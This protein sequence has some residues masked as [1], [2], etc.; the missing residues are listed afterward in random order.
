MLLVV[1]LFLFTAP[2]SAGTLAWSAEAIPSTVG[3]VLGPS[4]IDVRDIAVAANGTTIYAVPGDSTSDNVVYESNDAG[5]SWT[6]LGVDIKA[7]VVAVAPDD[8]HVVAIASKSAPAVWVTSNGGSTW[9]SLGTPQESGGAAAAIIHDIAISPASEGTHYIAVAG[10]EEND[11]ANVWYFD[12]GSPS[13]TWS[14]TNTLPGASS[15]NAMQ[16]VAFSPNFSSDKIMVAIGEN[17]NKSVTLEI[18]SLSTGAWNSSAGFTSY[19]INIVSND[20]I[21][22]LISASVSLAP[23]Y[24]G[25]DA[26]KRIAF[27]GL[28]VGG[29]ASAKATS[30]IYRLID[31]SRKELKTEVNIRSISFDGTSLVAGAYDSNIVYSSADP[32]ATMPAVSS[33]PSLK[34]PGG[35]NKVV[36][37]WAGSSVVAGT[38]GNE[39][40]FAVSRNNGG[41]FNDISLI[42]TA[43][44]NV[45]DVAVSTDGSKAYLVTDDGTDL[46]LWRKVSSWERVLSKQNTTAY[47]VRIAPDAPPDVVYVAQKGAKTIYCSKDG[48]ETEWFTYIST[49]EIQDLAVES[50]NVVYALSS[51]GKVSRSTVAGRSWETAQPTGLAEDT[52]HMI[53]S[54]SENNLLVGSTNGYVAYSTD[55]NLSWNKIPRQIQRGAG[56]VQVIADNNFTTNNIIY[57]A[58]D[59]RVQN[60]KKWVIGSSTGWSDIVK[61]FIGGGIYGLSIDNGT[62]YALEFN[63]AINQSTLWQCLSPTT[64]TSTSSSWTSRITYSTT[65]ADD[66]MV[67]LNAAPRALK[68]SSGDKLWAV[69]TNGTNKLYSFN[70]IL[71]GLVLKTPPH[72]YASLV[73]PVTGIAN[74]I[75]FRWSGLSTATEYKLYIARDKDFAGL[76]ATITVQSDLPTLVVFVGPDR[77]GDAKVKFAAG[78]N[79]YWRVKVT[80]P[81]YS[82]YSET[83]RFTTKPLLAPVPDLLVP[84]NGS[85]GVSQMPSFSWNP[86]SRGTEYRFVLADN[87]ALASPIVD[88]DVNSTGFAL[89]QELD[90]GKAYFWAVKPIAPVAGGWSTVANF[91]VKEKPAEPAPSLVVEQVPPLVIQLP[92]PPPPPPEIVIPPPSV[93]PASIVPA[94]IWAIIIIGAFLVSVVIFLIVRN[95]RVAEAYSG[96]VKKFRKGQSISFAA[97]LFDWMLDLKEKE[98]GERLLSSDEERLLGRIIMSRI[99]E[100]EKDQYLYKK[101]PK[102]AALL[103]YLWSH[104]GSRYETN[105]YLSKSFQAKANNVIDFLKC[106]L[107]VS[108]EAESGRPRKIDFSRAQYDSVA[109]V[110][111]PGDVF[112]ALIR[113]YGSELDILEDMESGDS[114]DK[115]IAYQFVR[116][117]NSV[118]NEIKEDRK[119]ED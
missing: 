96:S 83:R 77:A 80:Q 1:S 90:Y 33:T 117:H 91:T 4:G 38:S 101:F 103:L 52:G 110:V 39:S 14:E 85:T 95:F 41:A 26:A 109:Q 28:T 43:T 32:L 50:V 115:E 24:L 76:I 68:E 102:D 67:F 7:D 56:K 94:Y 54:A 40:A 116:I 12:I 111:D 72:N 114:P 73:N 13:I 19:P 8:R 64:A 88:L 34:S 107:P 18:L 45:R 16:A 44:T 66:A 84:A 106:Y 22:D 105:R 29:T 5:V 71:I 99:K 55:G 60:I 2:A 112:E 35:E 25:S 46:S 92:V 74:E 49:V 3:N 6:I 27:I 57:A 82:P 89:A 86:V 81:P 100:M 53:V 11:V 63:T 98:E 61:D 31:T 118:K 58:S 47:I 79:Y 30:G 42:D 51:E 59:A 17:D 9:N 37:T 113:L 97:H 70:N 10:E 20:G 93:P 65:D 69:K 23:E 36:V 119:A 108:E 62:L 48:G 75:T 78:T 15:V 104:Y 21:T 87:V